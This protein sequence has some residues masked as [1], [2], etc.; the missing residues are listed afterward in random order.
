MW[1]NSVDLVDQIVNGKN[2]I[3][4]QVLLDDVVVRQ[5]NSLFVDLTVTSLVHQ[6]SDGRIRWVTVGDVRLDDLQKFGSGLSHFDEHTV[7]DLVQSHQL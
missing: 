3:L 6:L 2:T 4:T 5:S 1:A 7:V